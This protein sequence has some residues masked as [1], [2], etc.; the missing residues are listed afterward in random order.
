MTI[1]LT[2]IIIMVIA[3]AII[4]FLLNLFVLRLPCPEGYS[5]LETHQIDDKTYYKCCKK[6]W[7]IQENEFKE[8]INCKILE[9]LPSYWE[10]WTE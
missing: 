6:E 2:D 3:A 5:R 4:V 10:E 9:A 8:N 7:A 1:E